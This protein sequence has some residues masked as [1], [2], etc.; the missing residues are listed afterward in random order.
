MMEK[1]RQKL[2][3]ALPTLRALVQW[4]GLAGLAG[5]AC[6]L[7]GAAFTWCVAQATALRTAHPWLLFLMPLAGLAIVWS[8]RTA[9]M[10]NDSGTNQIIASVRGGERPP[11]RLAPLIF[12][13]SVLTH[14]TGGSAGREGAALQIGGSISAGIGRL[15]RLGDRNVNTIIQCGM[16][17][18]FS[19]LFGTPLTATVFAL[20]VVNVGH[21]RYAALFPCLLSALTANAI[22]RL[23][24]LPGEAYHLSG[25]PEPG[26]GSMLRCGAL[27][28]LAALVSI[29]FCVLMHE[30]GRLY[31][32]YIPDQYLRG[33]AGAALVIA[34]TLAEGSG[35]YN[36]AGG[37]IIELAVEG[38][39][40]VPWAFLWKML[41]TALTLGAGFRGGEIVPTLFIGSTFGCAAGPLLGLDPAFGAAVSMI[42]LF[43]GV[44]NCPMASIFLAIELFGGEGLLF[45]A[46]A[47]ALSFLVS[48][49]YSLYSSQNIVYSKL[50]ARLN[51]PQ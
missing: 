38:Q 5:A 36:G 32:K 14:L 7:A 46:L 51:G 9:G 50:E 34:L 1:L 23:L 44:V 48:G 30:A 43:C 3:H 26:L 28:I 40:H 45:F 29:A 12:L 18:L 31:K 17:G 47:C 16:A 41:F 20:E 8:Y 11:V 39:V 4:L 25:L 37:H 10:E 49:Q 19:A 35:D 33:L 2:L 21:F 27:A 15:L 13:G 22:P 24:G 42:A 6:G